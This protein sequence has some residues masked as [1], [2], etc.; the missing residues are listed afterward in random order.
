MRTIDWYHSLKLSNFCSYMPFAIVVWF[1]SSYWSIWSALWVK[2]CYSFFISS[3]ELRDKNRYYLLLH[4]LDMSELLF[5]LKIGS[6]I[7]ALAFLI[8][9][10][11]EMLS[12][13]VLSLSLKLQHGW[14]K[15]VLNMNV[16]WKSKSSYS[17]QC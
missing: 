9:I 17:I 14:R 4:L 5:V 16:K 15:Y 13:R 12:C 1:E 8:Y 11:L 7:Y 2:L 10:S 3:S 6:F